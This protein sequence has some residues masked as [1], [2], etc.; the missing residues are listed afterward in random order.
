MTELLPSPEFE[1]KIRNAVS[2]PAPRSAFVE[3]L[4]SQLLQKAAP[5]TPKSRRF[6]PDNYRLSPRLA[7]GLVALF[8]VLIIALLATSPTV[9]EA[10]KRMFGYIPGAGIVE[11]NV[12][13]RVLAVPVTV[14][15]QGIT[16]TVTQGLVSS[17]KTVLTYR[18][19]NIPEA[20][21]A[22]D[23]AEGETPT[24]VCTLNDSLR[25]PDGTIYPPTSGQGSGWQLG[26]EYRETFGPLPPDVN[27]AT[28]L[29]A[30]LLGTAPG[31]A[32][33]NWEIS[34]AF[35][36]APPDLTVV[37]IIEISPVVPTPT[38]IP[39]TQPAPETTSIP[40]EPKSELTPEAMP[41][42]LERAIELE[43]GYILIGS[44]HS[45][46]TTN[47]LVTSP[48]PWYVRITD[49][50]GQDVPF[51]YATDIDLPISD[52]YTSGWAY[53]IQ[54]RYQ[55]WP[56]S[57]TLDNLDATLENIKAVFDFD[58]GPNPRAGQEWMLN[59][60]L[61]VGDYA[62]R[63]LTITRTGDGYAFS[64]QADPVVQGISVAIQSEGEPVK[65]MGG[66][67][68]GSGDGNINTSVAYAGPIPEGKLTVQISGLTVLV[69]GPWSLQWAPESPPVE[70]ST[71]TSSDQ[72]PCLTDEILA[73]VKAEVPAVLPE[74]LSGNFYIFGPNHDESLWGVSVFHL[75]DSSREFLTEGSWPIASPDGTKFIFTGNDGLAIHDFLTGET[76]TLLNTDT[77]DYRM[78]WSPDSTRIAFIRSSSD[79]MLV[80]NTDG[81]ELQVVRDNSAVYHNL[82][83]WADEAHLYITEPG[84]EGVYIQLLNL[85]DGSTQ[86]LF[87]ISSNKA[88]LVLSSDR[89]WLAFTD[90]LG[91]MMGNGLY[92]SHPD[93][94]ERHL[95]GA[96]NGRVLYFPVWSPD[97]RWLIISLPDLNDPSAP[98]VQVLIE[99]KTCQIIPLPDL[100]GEVYSWG[101]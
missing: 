25:L 22:R 14:E 59:Q 95:V 63:V 18:V 36:P 15:R 81:S 41:I 33:E 76:R 72:Q 101:P 87:P 21:L 92:I 47:G 68:G 40:S 62:L 26:F 24:P 31:L 70:D 57:I 84:P 43:D 10:M 4:R 83:S 90:L 89:Q 13:L 49:A 11:Q 55:V 58:T 86:N 45:I 98:T 38:Q 2:A 69:P 67:G 52:P 97:N 42:T 48:Y 80:V 91:G 16:L 66:G 79:Q 19:E 46:T 44:F 100:G 82:I 28:L 1:E 6:S 50:N 54:G 74:Q 8:L 75:A 64:F 5:M 35:V 60:D 37:P 23:F 85:T 99:L 94:S 73:Q 39:S 12:P 96:L 3:R 56:L 32:P 88:D 65:P 34:L 7:W 53:Q 78:V 51:D 93:G 20:A 29:V 9:V 71:E 30:C 77:S 17:D 61:Q 27:R